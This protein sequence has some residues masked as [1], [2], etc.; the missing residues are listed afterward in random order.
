MDLKKITIMKINSAKK[1]LASKKTHS[2]ILEDFPD[3]TED[4]IFA[5]LE[6]AADR[7]RPWCRSRTVL[8]AV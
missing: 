2:Q 7:E 3:L 8:R 5:C 6:Y 4:D 1:L